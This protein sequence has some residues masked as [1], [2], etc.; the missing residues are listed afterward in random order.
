M[1][2]E[3]I[4]WDWNGTVLNDAWLCL[5]VM[6]ESL[7]K[8]AL[9][10]LSQERYE[11]VFTI[12]VHDYYTALGFDFTRESFEKA[13]MEFMLSYNSRNREAEIQED[14]LS[15]IKKIASS[16]A[17]QSILS[18]YHQDDLINLVTHYELDHYFD[19]IV[20]IQDYY[21]KGK[22][23]QGLDLIEKLDVDPENILMFGDLIHDA[24]VAEAMGIDCILI[25]R[26][27]QNR[28]RL[29][30]TGLP[31]HDKLELSLLE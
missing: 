11:A 5:E 3:H 28:E 20:G 27:N 31:V 15:L 24:E 29:E 9:P 30:S 14:S 13:G 23:A 2:Y 18:A 8:R 7:T 6:N 26:G 12:P 1:K 21:A 19:H 16:Q 22:I 4:I 10:T 25:T 17:S